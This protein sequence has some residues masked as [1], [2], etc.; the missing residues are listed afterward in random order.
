MKKTTKL[1]ALVL[2]LVMMVSAFAA[3]G[4]SDTN[5][6]EKTL[7]IGTQ[8]F[9]GK[10]S[11]FFYT[12]AYENDVLGLVN[13]GLLGSD[14]E[15]AV[16]LKGI[17]GEVRPYNGTDYTYTGIADCVVTENADGTVY[18]DFTLKEGVKFSDGTEMDIDDVIFSLYVLLDPAY[19]GVST[20]YALPIEGLDEYRKNNIMLSALLGQLGEE[21]TDFT[22][23]TEEQQAAFWAAVNDGLV[24]FA[25]EIVDYCA[26]AGYAADG[27]DV[28]TAASAWGFDGL[29]AT[30]TAKDF[31][32]AIGAAYDWSFSAMEAETAG[33][34]LADLIPADVYAYAG[35]NVSTG[36]SAA[37]VTGIQKTGD[38]SLRIVLTELDATAIYQMGQTIVPM[39]Y[40]GEE[41]LYDY[42][43]NKFGFVKGDMSDV[44]SVTTKP[45]GAGPYTFESYEN[46]VVT[47]KA[48]P[49]YWKGEPK[50][51]YIK[52]QEGQDAD[53]VPGVVAGTIDITDPSYSAETAKAI[54]DANGGEVTGSKITTNMV[55][56]LGYGYIGFAA[57]NVCVGGE[58]GS[59]A[60]KNLRKAIATVISVYR[61]VA[62]DSYYGEF[63]NVINYPISDTS[64]AAPRVTDEGYKVAFSVDAEGNDIYTE[65]MTAE[66]KYAAAQKAALGFFE[67]AGYTVADGKVTAAPEGAKMAYEVMV[68]GGGIG[69][70]PVFMALTQAAASL[71]EIGF[72]LIVSDM[73]NFA[74]MTDAVNSGT[75]E[76]FGMAWQATPDPDMYQIY[77]SEGGSNEKAYWIKDAALDKLIMDARQS[78]DQTYRKTLYKQALDIVADWAV[79]IPMYQRQ[80]CI[81]FSTERVNM[82]TVT[83]DITTFWGW[84]NDIEK[85]EMN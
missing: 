31:A 35:T 28:A 75:A 30:A 70:H 45:V 22:Y 65:G 73:A 21:N 39:H 76:M 17:E 79:E 26:A 62:I 36:E 81:I 9:D 82:E 34:A 55:A 12:N 54:A 48:N 15:G 57:K 58:S 59:E 51:D 4:G 78:T 69:D 23:V 49:N 5:E 10:F 84:A 27:N 14:R 40:Y 47:L 38:N 37:N 50:I 16:V 32:L 13:V 43:N 42:E 72:D 20:F 41:S 19:D 44:K 83:P 3:C 60:S 11:P 25:Q 33:S 7:V 8:N 53:K 80:N 64:W 63:A 2:A 77:H 29:P 18:Y 56:N 67:A 6:E 68:G 66:E 61:D 74:E 85:L 1:I 71:K 24:K 52:F 46:G